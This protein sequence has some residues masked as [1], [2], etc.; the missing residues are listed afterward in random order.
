MVF[1]M[2]AVLLVPMEEPSEGDALADVARADFYLAPGKEAWMV[3]AP[4]PPG[5]GQP[6]YGYP[7][8]IEPYA[9]DSE[10]GGLLA[11]Y[12]G[13]EAFWFRREPLGLPT[14]PPGR[15]PDI[16]RLVER[17]QYADDIPFLLFSPKKASW[18]RFWQWD[19]KVPLVVYLPGCGEQGTDLTLQFRQTACFGTVCSER[20]QREH[21]AWMLVPMPPAR[22]NTNVV[23]GY[24]AQPRAPLISLYDDLVLKVVSESE[25]AGGQAP[26]ID[27]SRI[28][29]TGLGSG[30]TMAQAM[31][32]DHPGRYA[33]VVLVW[34]R[35]YC[36]PAVHPDA[37]GTWRYVYEK[38]TDPQPETPRERESR[39][40]FDEFMSAFSNAVVRLGGDFSIQYSAK[41]PEDGWWWDACWKSDELWEWC[42]S[43]HSNGEVEVRQ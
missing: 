21:A 15:A 37:P 23:K 27:R 17:G 11:A 3:P 32:F 9:V 40:W 12:P 14:C 42:F 13:L 19:E 43:K 2:L 1:L 41:R 31:A 7:S 5:D 38:Q 36:T 8:K 35:P 34:T 28:Y 33:V 30:A 24:P 29:L 39:A 10:L 20:F 18:W 16:A 22:A 25:L 4:Y 6:G 26:A